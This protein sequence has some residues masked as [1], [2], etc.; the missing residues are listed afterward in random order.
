MSA[1]PRRPVLLYDGPCGLCNRVVRRLLRADQAGR[2]H[3]APLQSAPAQAYLRAQGLPVADFDSLV[4]VPDWNDPAPGA[5]QL[6]TDGAL[7]ACAVAGGGLWRAVGWMRFIPAAVRDLGY[8][9][10]ARSRYALF[11]EYR[12]RSL[13][14]PEWE[15]RFL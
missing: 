9:L 3:Y 14:N 2:L 13:E 6:R 8:K 1:A 4:F 5:Y 11:G 7:A 15:R 12:P 10:V